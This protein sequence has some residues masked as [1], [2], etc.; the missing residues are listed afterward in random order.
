MNHGPHVLIVSRDQM[1]LQSRALILGT[2]F[3][4]EAAGRVPEAELA[5]ARISFDL[6]VL[7]YSLSDNEYLRMI[8]MCGRQDP[9]PK[10][11]LS[12][13]AAGGYR[14]VGGDGA[15]TVDGGPYEL[16][17]KSAEVTGF[18]LKPIGRAAQHS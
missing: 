16:L 17:K 6:V 9:Q 5:M 8:D 18:P 2:Y 12:N 10:I 15:Y 4:V 7:C 1:L 13:A 14:R 11:L 3:Q